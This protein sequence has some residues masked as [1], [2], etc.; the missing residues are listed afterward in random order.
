MARRLLNLLLAFGAMVVGIEGLRRAADWWSGVAAPSTFA[1][2]ALLACLPLIALLWWRHLSS[3]GKG[4]GQC[5]DAARRHDG[6][7]R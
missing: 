7:S 3:F 2:F 5:L 6:D 4:R 1:D